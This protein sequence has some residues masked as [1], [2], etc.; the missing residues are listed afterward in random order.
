MHC[1]SWWASPGSISGVHY[2]SDVVIG[3]LAG[4][5]LAVAVRAAL[6]PVLALVGAAP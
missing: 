1:R 3:A 2:P 5:F 6:H 4:S